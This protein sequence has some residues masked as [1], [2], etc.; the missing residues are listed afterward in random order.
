MVR[1]LAY[2]LLN[3]LLKLDELRAE[4]GSMLDGPAALASINAEIAEQLAAEKSA[5]RDAAMPP[6]VDPDAIDAL[7]ALS[8]AALNLVRLLEHYES[9]IVSLHPQG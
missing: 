3:P 1:A 2:L 9:Q 6:V 5:R 8:D 7:R 4:L